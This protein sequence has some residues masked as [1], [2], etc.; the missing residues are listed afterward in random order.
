M[1]SPM[2][3]FGATTAVLIATAIVISLVGERLGG[4]QFV[5]ASAH[6]AA[7]AGSPTSDVLP[8]D[9]S[10][11]LSALMPARGRTHALAVTPEGEPIAVDAPL[12][13]PVTTAET[14]DAGAAPTS[15]S[16]QAAPPPPARTAAPP[17]PTSQPAIAPATC[18]ATWF[19]YPRLG[20]AG[21][22]VPYG[23]CLGSTDIG[24]SIRSFTC[25]SPFYLMGHA[26][27]QFGKITQWRAGDVV[28]A[29][30]RTF[31]ITGA[32]TQN[33]CEPPARAPS[34]LSLQTSLSTGGCGSVLVVQGN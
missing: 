6:E 1:L 11:D 13:V 28:T 2:N 25:I 20:I 21:A 9:P 16:P 17:A 27:T 24:T 18:P 5:P 12:A 10:A 14:A 26:Y 7:V 30:G 29:S 31:T 33:S 22:I 3:R 19:C 32:F 15:V 23:D 4:A 34:P 8:V